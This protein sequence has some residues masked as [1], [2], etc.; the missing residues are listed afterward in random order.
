MPVTA[1]DTAINLH[2]DYNGA[3]VISAAF[4]GLDIS[5]TTITYG[6]TVSQPLYRTPEQALS[7]SVSLD[8]RASDTFL[9]NQPFSFTPGFVNGRA[10]ATIVR[11]G[12]DWV[13]RRA[14][15]V[16]AIRSTVNR[17]LPVFGA[18]NSAQQPNADFTYWLGQVQYVRAFG[19]SQV[20][21]KGGLQLSGAPLFPFEQLSIGGPDTVRGFPVNTLL[22]DNGILLSLEGRVPIAR[23]RLPAVTGA[24]TVLRVAPFVD[25]GS[26][27]NTG[28]PT[29]HPNTLAS[30][31]VGLLWA[32]N[33]AV[34]AQ[35]YYGHGFETIQG[36]GH[37]LQE[38]GIYFRVVSSV[39]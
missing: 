16:L 3:G 8:Q 10:S 21:A 33:Q 39:F 23:F 24:E 12:V 5:S 25:F 15:Q 35:V 26:G 30:V 19:D 6:A 17:G 32:I 2:W 4:S 9:L 31:G 20:V 37:S 11:I 29:P 36:L 1:A 38:D 7:L 34:S 14:D 22:T 13:D 28:Q 27:W 18:T